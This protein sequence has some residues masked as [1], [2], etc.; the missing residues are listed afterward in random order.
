[1]PIGSNFDNYLEDEGYREEVESMT[2][3]RVWV[4]KIQQSIDKKGIKQTP[5]GKKCPYKTL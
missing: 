2:F 4:W 1:M 3:K 5:D